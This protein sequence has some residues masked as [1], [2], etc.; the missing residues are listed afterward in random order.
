MLLLLWGRRPEQKDEHLLD[1][2][3][4]MAYCSTLGELSFGEG[5]WTQSTRCFELPSRRTRN[6]C[7]RSRGRG[8]LHESKIWVEVRRTTVR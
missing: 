8:G 7:N 6:V 3:S 2:S 1:F 5:K 4:L